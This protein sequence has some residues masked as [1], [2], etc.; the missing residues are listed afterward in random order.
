MIILRNKHCCL[1]TLPSKNVLSVSICHILLHHACFLSVS[2]LN[3]SPV[4]FSFIRNFCLFFLSEYTLLHFIVH[5]T[6]KKYLE[7]PLR[8]KMVY[9]FLYAPVFFL[10]YPW[11]PIFSPWPNCAFLWLPMAVEIPQFYKVRKM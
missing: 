2:P 4:K 9:L 10:C 5:F 7:W 3:L 1:R 6:C 8:L 11:Y